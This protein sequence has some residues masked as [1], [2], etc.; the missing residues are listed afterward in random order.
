[1]ICALDSCY[2]NCDGCRSGEGCVD[3]QCFQKKYCIERVLYGCWECF[4]FPC[5][6][7]Y[8]ANSHP[9]KGQFIGCVSYIKK[10]NFRLIGE[11]EDPEDGLVNR[12]ELNSKNKHIIYGFSQTPL[13]RLCLA[14]INP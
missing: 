11:F 7:G 6:K 2:A 14:G 5:G 13:T 4:D 9:S 10:V 3:G 8:F 1:M 12:W